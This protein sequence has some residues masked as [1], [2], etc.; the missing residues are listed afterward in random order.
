MSL[1][2]PLNNWAVATAYPA[3][4]ISGCAARDFS[5]ML[6]RALH[7]DGVHVANHFGAKV[8][9]AA[10]AG[11][12]GAGD[13]G[14]AAF[15]LLFAG[16]LTAKEPILGLS[17]R[18][19]NVNSIAEAHGMADL[20][21][22]AYRTA[23]SHQGLVLIAVVPWPPTGIWSRTPIRSTEAFAGMRVRA[24][25]ESSKRVMEDLGAHVVSL[26][27][28]QALHQ[29]KE[30]NIDAVISSGDG[31]AGRAY[32]AVLP[33]FTALRYAYPLS[34]L[35]ASKRFIDSLSTTQRAAIFG[36]G[37][38]TERLAWR[39]LPERVRQN[40]RAMSDWGVTVHDPVPASLS[41]AL[42]RVA[43]AETSADIETDYETTQMLSLFRS[44]QSPS[45]SCDAR[46]HW[47]AKR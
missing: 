35:V 15:G 8:V 43:K 23:L 22:P 7:D 20:A 11:D 5:R 38:E 41:D 1:E 33:N 36:A 21:T 9:P 25:D 40:Y 45:E 19:Y 16:D 28:Q 37:R 13:Q 10:L 30:G 3:D 42:E 34:F 39:R 32:A 46:T 27:I 6:E 12:Q 44:C 18:P 4:T 14:N 29:L 47:Q 17:V 26:P 31:D 24:Y 2:Q